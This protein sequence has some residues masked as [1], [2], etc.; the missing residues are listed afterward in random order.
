MKA[1][2][3]FEYDP[4]NPF[5]VNTIQTMQ[6]GYKFRNILWELDQYLRSKLKYEAIPE[7]ANKAYQDTRD[8][9]HELH[10]LIGTEGVDLNDE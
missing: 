8:K 2:F 4:E 3:T 10:E 6:N 9:L 5:E 7:D 1:T